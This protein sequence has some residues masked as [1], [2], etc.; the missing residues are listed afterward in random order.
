[1]LGL[2]PHRPTVAF[3]APRSQGAGFFLCASALCA[4]SL[5]GRGLI[6]G[7]LI[8]ERFDA[9]VRLS[10]TIAQDMVAVRIGPNMRTV[11]VASP[12]YFSGTSRSHSQRS[13][14]SRES[15][16]FLAAFRHVLHAWLI[17]SDALAE[18]V[19]AAGPL[20]SCRSAAEAGLPWAKVPRARRRRNDGNAGW[21][22][23]VMRRITF[24]RRDPS[25]SVRRG[26]WFGTDFT[27]GALGGNPRLASSISIKNARSSEERKRGRRG[28]RTGRGYCRRV[29]S[30]WRV[31]LGRRLISPEP[32]P[33]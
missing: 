22:R 16:R 32:Q 6:G 33:D 13:S 19:K 12:A 8:E 15:R 28:A 1:V 26:L 18:Q 29:N 25:R 24:V 31:E 2:P 21:S 20:D 7:R 4:G 3:E 23:N 17:G 14:C 10:E 5:C 9:G 27:M 11:A 30:C